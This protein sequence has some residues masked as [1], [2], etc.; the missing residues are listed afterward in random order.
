MK[1]TRAFVLVAAASAASSLDTGSISVDGATASKGRRYDGIGGLSNSCAPWLKSYP[2]PQRS[3]ILD[4]LFKPNFGASVHVLKIEIGGD[5]HST[6][7]TE[8]S[9]Q[10]SADGPIDMHVGWEWWIAVEAKKRNPD[11]VISALPWGYP[12]WIKESAGDESLVYDYLI[13]WVNGMKSE[14]NI[15]VDYIGLHNEG[16]PTGSPATSVDGFRAALDSAGLTKLQIVSSDGHDFGVCNEL[17]KAGHDSDFFKAVSVIGVHEPLRSTEAVPEHCLAT[18]KP[19]WSSESYTTY[20]DSNGGGCWAR[21]L[22]WGW[23]KGS[24]T[25]HMAWNLIQSYPTE[26]SGMSYQGHGLMW[27]DVPWSGHYT[28]NS[29]IWVTAHYTQTSEVGW[30]Y[31]PVG[32]GSGDLPSG[33]TFLTMVSDADANGK[34]EFALVAQTMEYTNS[35]CFKDAHAAFDVSN[36][37]VVFSLSSDLIPKSKVLYV[38]QT[39]LFPGDPIDPYE[40]L[41][42]SRNIYYE[43]LPQIE[44]DASGTVTLELPINTVVTVSTRAGARGSHPIPAT[45]PFPSKYCDDLSSY[46][47][48]ENGRYF[49]DQQGVFVMAADASEGKLF[50]QVVPVEPDE[51]HGWGKIL[52]PQSFVGPPTE[53]ANISCSVRPLSEG[54]G[55]VGVGGQSKTVSSMTSDPNM[56]AIFG[57]GTWAVAGQ[58]GSVAA[59]KNGWFDLELRVSPDR[60]FEALVGG[61]VVATGNGD[62]KGGFPFLGSSYSAGTGFRDLCIE[63][64][65]SAP[66]P[67]PT[68][69]TPPPSPPPPADA[70]LVMAS[71]VTD[72]PRQMW[73]FTGEDGGEAGNLQPSSDPLMCL[74]WSKA[75]DLILS[76]CSTSANTLEWSFES[77]RNVFYSVGTAPCL[78]SK[79]GSQ[80]HIC[81]DETKQGKMDLFDCWF[82]FSNSPNSNQKFTYDP[83]L[84]ASPLGHGGQ[85]LGAYFEHERSSLV[86]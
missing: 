50:Q 62:W 21:A 30:R 17:E 2:E 39:Q 51:W 5:A 57:N 31:L 82:D 52:H 67:A 28:V 71:C 45:G 14:F 59:P 66:T 37:T 42:D 68:T 34:R 72:E 12:G 35:K 41:P 18:G 64:H 40:D 53:T 15:T 19:I 74:D 48:G 60:S 3:H 1:L 6:I 47:S 29:P 13:S 36:Q 83:S 27:A 70:G 63:S 46:E 4:Y 8:A 61:Q 77:A 81:L 58:S 9:H 56:L 38:R 44:L 79:H 75:P 16:V 78:A 24:V 65:G 54:F 26:G 73:T 7:N 22:N 49:I 20:S 76:P 55:G 10:H 69:T 23:V 11:I 84:G 33:G 85:C 25:A 32:S 80:C 86:I 43:E